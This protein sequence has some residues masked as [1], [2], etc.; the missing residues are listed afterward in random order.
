MRG[1]D[2]DMKH[3][4]S[5]VHGAFRTLGNESGIT[6][7]NEPKGGTVGTGI[8]LFFIASGA[9]LTFA[10]DVND[11]DGFNLDAAGVIL[12][13]VGLLGMLWSMLAWDDWRPVRRR[14][15]D[16]DVV[17]RRE[18]ADEAPLTGRDSYVVDREVPV[19]RTIRRVHH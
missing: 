19:R 10:V 9:I 13:V 14:T 16:D 18:Y 4:S 15:Y 17:V 12:M 11:S 1:R 5:A 3:F 8:S 7:P 2:V 6:S